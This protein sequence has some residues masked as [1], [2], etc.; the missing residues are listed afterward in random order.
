VRTTS[1]SFA[2]TINA[3]EQRSAT[4]SRKRRQAP[5][6]EQLFETEADDDQLAQGLKMMEEELGKLESSEDEGEVDPICGDGEVESDSDLKESSLEFYDAMA[7]RSKDKK[8]RKK[9]LYE[10]APKFPG[11]ESEVHGKWILYCWFGNNIFCF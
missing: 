6:A 3:I 7:K 1:K 4:E 5:F 11:S 8:S 9:S 2:S 10:V